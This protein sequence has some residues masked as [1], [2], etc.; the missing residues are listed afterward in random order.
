MLHYSQT[1]SASP[2]CCCSGSLGHWKGERSSFRSS[3]T[4]A[5]LIDA[6]NQPGAFLHANTSTGKADYLK[7]QCVITRR[8]AMSL[9]TSSDFY[10]NPG[11]YQNN[12]TAN[13]HFYITQTCGVQMVSY[14]I[15]CD[16]QQ[17][18]HSYNAFGVFT[19]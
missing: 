12:V 8:T 14:C 5:W 7:V 18:Q 11:D 17:I 9:K 13:V 2:S 6:L 3:V 4:A 19:F 16:V 1:T 15:E 10:K